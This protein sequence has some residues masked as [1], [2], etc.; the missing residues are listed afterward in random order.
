MYFLSV[1]GFVVLVT[2][3]VV[4]AL[5]CSIFI[6]FGVENVLDSVSSI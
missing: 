4:V 1:F 2:V 5:A 3:V 6:E